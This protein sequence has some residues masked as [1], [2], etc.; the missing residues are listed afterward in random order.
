MKAVSRFGFTLVEMMIVT[1]VIL[2]ILAI[3]VPAYQRQILR[4]KEAKLKSDLRVVRE[5]M[6]RMATDTGCYPADPADLA[7]TLAPAQCY[8]ANATNAPW[9]ITPLPSGRWAGPYVQAMPRI[10]PI[11]LG[12]AGGYRMPSGWIYDSTLYGA[13]YVSR[14]SSAGISTEGPPYCNW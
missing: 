9:P 2:V 11:F 13:T 14:S 4:A 1:S 12:S 5:A 10:D 6:E 3:A 8:L 7:A